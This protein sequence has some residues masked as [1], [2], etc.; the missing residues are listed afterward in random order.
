[1]AGSRKHLVE[2]LIKTNMRF[3]GHVMRGSS[4][5]LPRLVLE[6]MKEGR[7][8]RTWGYDVKE[9]SGCDSIGSA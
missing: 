4:G 8:R 9:W 5:F 2:D 7:P 1:M 6:G 3:V